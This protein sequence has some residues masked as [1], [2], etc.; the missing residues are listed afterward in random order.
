MCMDPAANHPL[1]LF[2]G[3]F[4]G[5]HCQGIALDERNGFAY[6]SFTTMLVKTD[7]QGRLIGSVRGLTG[8]LGCIAFHPEDG[9]VYGSLEYKDDVI[10]RAVRERS[11]GGHVEDAFYVVRFDGDRITCPDLDACRDGVMTA[12][13]LKEVVDDFHGEAVV[14]GRVFPHRYGCSGI[15]GLSFG[16]IPGGADPKEYLFVCYGIYSDLER[17]DNDHQVLLCYDTAGWDAFAAPLSQTALHHQ[18][19]EKPDRKFF[20]Y[21]GNTT[22]GVQNL[23]YD[24]CT[25]HFLM[26]VYRGK[27]PAFSNHPLYVIDGGSAPESRPLRGLSE[28]GETL[29]LLHTENGVDPTGIEFPFGSTGLYSFGDGFFAVSEEEKSELGYATHVRLYRWDGHG[30]LQAVEK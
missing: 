24:P 30:P 23:E 16:K 1:S 27:K 10:G 28:M 18:G 19:P 2:S 11:G 6:F 25:G 4:D 22:Y 21:T 12:V 3:W 8:H 9:C 17:T 5:G 20:V 29:S 15:D 7:F 26:A 14:N 13:C